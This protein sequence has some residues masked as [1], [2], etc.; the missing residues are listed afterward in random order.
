MKL[1]S[2]LF[3]FFSL[4]LA[5]PKAAPSTFSGVVVYT[6]PS[7]YTDPRVLYARTAQLPDGDILA[8]WENYS[9]EPPPVYFP[10]YR[11]SD[12]G[13]TW[14]EL[15]RVQD[16]V[17]GWGL[18]Y[19]PFLYILPE[20][21]GD[22]PS[23]TVLLAGSSIPTDLS[24]TQIDLYA[25]RDK[26]ATWKFV[27]HIAAGGRAVPNNGLT[28]VW[29]P[30]LMYY[31]KTLICYYSDQR[32]NAT[33]GQK[34]VHQTTKDMRTWGAVIDDVAY[35]KYTDRPGMPTV[36][37]LPNEKYIMAYEYGG[38]PAIK[39]SYQFP[40][41]YK[42][43][44]DPEKFGPATG[45]SLKATDGTIPTGSP[46]IVWSPVGGKNGTL[47]VSSGS[48]SQVFVNTGLGEGAWRKVSTPEGV[49]YTRHLKVLGDGSKLL[50]MGGGHLPPS[51]TN[52]VT[53][54]AMD[55]SKL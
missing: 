30:F 51:T 1:L 9:P 11:S 52:K 37:Q 54:S 10:I 48:Q 23:G 46:Y 41:Y 15:S 27:S 35:P 45:I 20:D 34:M 39:S 25:S 17:N 44:S 28:P 33:H 12:G 40:V 50:I 47:I 42:I 49:S 6:P 21:M 14:K 32:D 31:Q 53:V 7:N 36:A 19:Q 16:Q 13:Y 8:T 4:A 55:I 29:E 43:V 18:R 38:G 2:T 22:Y 3:P 26:G 5:R 24:R